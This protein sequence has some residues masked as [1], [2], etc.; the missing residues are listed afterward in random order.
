MKPLE[1]DD[2]KYTVIREGGSCIVLR[3]GEPWRDV[4]GD[5][6][7]NSLVT[8]IEDLQEQLDKMENCPTC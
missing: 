1:L 4:T 7:F 2:G 6:C 5:K 8:R 3:Y